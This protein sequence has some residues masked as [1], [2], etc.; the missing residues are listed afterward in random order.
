M[1]F[2]FLNYRIRDRMLIRTWHCMLHILMRLS[3]KRSS[4][5]RRWSTLM[6]QET[7]ETFQ[8][9]TFVVIGALVNRRIDFDQIRREC[10]IIQFTNWINQLGQV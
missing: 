2:N 9:T 6:D 10:E 4:Q 3:L 1:H 7:S 8:Q 5:L